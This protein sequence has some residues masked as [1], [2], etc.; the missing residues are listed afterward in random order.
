MVRLVQAMTSPTHA[1]L[2]LF[3]TIGYYVLA[4]VINYFDAESSVGTI[5]IRF[6]SLVVLFVAARRIPKRYITPV[7]PV[8]LPGIV[9]LACYT[10]R[11]TENMLVQG[12]PIPPDNAQ[13]MLIY[14][15]FFCNA[16][17]RYCAISTGDFRS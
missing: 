14:L 6:G 11:L 9:F 12:L 15:F 16:G 10:V 13:V 7:V 17:R 1:L 8:L 2:L 4:G 3:P 5:A